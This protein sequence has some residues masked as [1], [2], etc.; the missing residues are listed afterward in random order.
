[1][2]ID[3]RMAGHTGIGRYVTGLLRYVADHRDDYSFE[4]VAL[5]RTSSPDHDSLKVRQLSAACKVFSAGEQV[6][7][8]RLIAKVNARLVHVP[9][10]NAP[11]LTRTPVMITI[12][13]CA[14]DRVPAERPSF[15]AYAYYKAMMKSALRKA[16]K[17]IAASH[18]T[19]A[20]LLDI[21]DVPEEKVTVIHH[22]IDLRTFHAGE[23]SGT[24]WPAVEARWKLDVPYVLYVGLVRP[25]KNIQTLLIA[26]RRA[27]DRWRE[28]FKLLMA[29]PGDS[30]FIDVPREA[31]VLGIPDMVVQTGVI[32]DEELRVLYKH[33]SM[34][35]L[36]SL[37]E[38]FGFPLLEGMASGTPVIA[39]DIPVHREVAGEA[40]L[41]VPPRDVDAWGDALVRVFGDSAFARGL[42]ARGLERVKGFS[43]N[44]SARRTLALYE[45]LLSA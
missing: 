9:H 2:V 38:G 13:D 19:R 43:L 11:L 26:V 32:P 36:P 21:Y 14:F 24:A 35:V 5:T 15:L 23:T 33:A 16:V 10:F 7:V 17:I 18:G 31:R 37:V 44:V 6:E 8:P 41:L 25:R 45:D 3:A 22:G 30:R 28:R 12:Q 4:V 39:S 40:A 1:M 29:G 27:R 20:D 42:T 34:V